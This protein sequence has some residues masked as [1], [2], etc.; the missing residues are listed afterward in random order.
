MNR[1]SD[2]PIKI[3][4]KRTRYTFKLVDHPSEKGTVESR[5]SFNR[6][7]QDLIE[8]PALLQCGPTFAQEM[9]IAHD[10]NQWVLAGK[11][12]ADDA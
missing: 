5:T 12:E 11:A 2:K 4:E 1:I 7:L 8:T 6:F 10:G 9:V 3:G